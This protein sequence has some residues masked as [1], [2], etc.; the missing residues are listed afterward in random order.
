MMS[1]F[2]LAGITLNA[3]TEDKDV[4]Q[5]EHGMIGNT[6]AKSSAYA[7][8]QDPGAQWFPDATLGL[9]IHWGISSVKDLGISWPM[10]PGRALAKVTLDSA[11]IKRIVAERDYNLSGEPPAITPNDYW[12]MAKE[13]NPV[14]YDPDKWIKAAKEAGFTYAVLTTKHHEGFAMWPSKY[15]NFSTINYMGGRDLI[16]PFIDACRKYGL[17]V[18]LYYSPPDWYF[19]RDYMNF[20]YYR[21]PW[22]NPGLPSLDANLNPRK[23]KKT[24]EE[25]E[26]HQQE[27]AQFVKGQIHEIL[28]RWGKIDLLW[29][30]GSA[31]VP[32]GNNLVTQEE[33]RKI[34]PGIVIN[35]RMHKKG[36]F[37]T[38]ERTPPE[39]D[40]G[41]IWA[42]FCDPWT[43]DW[44][45]S[46]NIPFR[47]NAFVL[48][49]LVS[50]RAWKVNFLLGVG[51]NFKGEFSKGVYDNMKVLKKWMK[52]ND[53]SLKEAG[54]LPANEEASVP[55]TACENLRYLFTIPRFRDGGKFEEDRLPAQNTT[56]TLKTTR[57]PKSVTILESGKKLSYRQTGNTI[58]VLLPAQLR[59]NLVDVVK[60]ELE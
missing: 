50:A 9:F 37:K 31:K 43:G 3:Q 4:V 21:A 28:T 24:Q 36:D 22:K 14:D 33:I 49:E 17:K 53:A 15:G 56:L 57:N 44:T 35:P 1:G 47:S 13:F 54:Q 10:I 34:Q 16:K 29:F 25:I 12:A 51:P 45:R 38:F 27:Y 20:L 40:P 30:D 6:N 46:T 26:R 23:D 59:T 18:G 41:N 60:I 58:T 7:H 42:E 48:G 32:N 8:T 11:E 52:A 19:N 2:I 5:T 55:A 39:K